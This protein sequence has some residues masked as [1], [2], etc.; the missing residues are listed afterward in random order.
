MN[1]EL[2]RA[3]E[4]LLQARRARGAVQIPAVGVVLSTAVGA[5]PR[6]VPGDRV[7]DTQ[8]GE[9]GTVEHAYRENVVG[10]AAER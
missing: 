2:A 9:E 5:T 10:P 3:R 7:F 4:R 1:E 6:F 8:T